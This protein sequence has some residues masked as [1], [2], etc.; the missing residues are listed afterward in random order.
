[1]TNQS[2]LRKSQDLDNLYTEP[3]AAHFL[4]FTPR[5]LQ[6]WR[7]RGEGPK[8]VRVSSRAI[9]YRKIDLDNWIKERLKS[10]TSED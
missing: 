8:F 9:R 6:A 1:M 4:N 5:C 3:Q 10:S 2:F 7:Q